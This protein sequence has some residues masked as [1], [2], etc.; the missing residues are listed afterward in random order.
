[1]ILTFIK[2]I[3]WGWGEDACFFLGDFGI[4]FFIIY[5]RYFL[6]FLDGIRFFLNA[7]SDR[8]FAPIAGELRIGAD[9]FIFLDL[10]WCGVRSA[11]EC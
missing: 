10:G 2:I 6:W 11:D 1:M 7:D 8:G 3:F 9:F 5:G 4:S